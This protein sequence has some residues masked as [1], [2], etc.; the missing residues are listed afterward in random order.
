VFAADL[1]ANASM[2]AALRAAAAA[3]L[4]VYGECGGLMYLGEGIVDAA[5]RHH[6]MVGLV[7]RWSVMD[8]PRVTLGYRVATAC[9]PSFL[10]PAGASVRGHEFHWS[11]LDAPP[12]PAEAA[13]HLAAATGQPLGPEGFV[14][15]PR[16]NVLATYAHVHFAA[17]QRL[18]GTFVDAAAGS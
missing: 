10:L 11:A 15:G 8:R 13:Y 4:P 1:A 2:R 9:R 17:D 14:T 5:G 3:G 6:K 16:G 7:P 18:A 12:T